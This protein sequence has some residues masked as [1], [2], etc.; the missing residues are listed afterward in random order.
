MK[1]I[2]IL[3]GNNFMA[4]YNILEIVLCKN[5]PLVKTKVN[6]EGS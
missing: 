1:I 4:K 2:N 3:C 5:R 6:K